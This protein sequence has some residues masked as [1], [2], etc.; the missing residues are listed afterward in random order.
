MGSIIRSRSRSNPYAKPKPPRMGRWDIQGLRAFAVLAVVFDH[1]FAQP[2]GGFVG[3]DIFFVISG[4]LITGLLVRE[5]ER[6]GHISFVGFYRRRIKR[7][8]PA[9][10]LVLIVTAVASHAIFNSVRSKSISTDAIWAFLFGANWHFRDI[11]TDYF[12]ASAAISPLQH[13]WSLSIEEQFYFVWPWVMLAVFALLLGR[14]VSFNRAR[15]VI[16]VVITAATVGSF[17]WALHETSTNATGAYFSTFS[18]AWELGLG[19]MCAVATPIFYRLSDALRPVLAWIGLTAITAS[20]FVVDASGGFP[21]PWAALPVAATALVIVA[22][23]HP[24]KGWQQ[25]FLVPLTNPVS[26]Y[27][28]DVSYSLYLWHFPV[29]IIGKDALGETTKDELILLVVMALLSVFSFHLVEDPIRHSTLWEMTRQKRRDRRAPY[30]PTTNAVTFRNTAIAFLSCVVLGANAVAFR[31]VEQP[32]VIELPQPPAFGTGNTPKAPL[33]PLQA[34][35]QTKI[36]AAISASDWPSLSPSFEQV[37]SGPSA[38]D[39]VHSCGR[40]AHVNVAACSWGANDARR[41]AVIAGDSISVLYAVT[42]RKMFEDLGGW[43]VY[44]YGGF[45]CPFTKA[46]VKADDPVLQQNCPGRNADAVKAIRDLRPDLLVI[47]NSVNPST[48]VGADV[49]MDEGSWAADLAAILRP[50]IKDA[51]HTV[52]ISPPPPDRTLSE[53]YAPHRSPTECVGRITDQWR[54]RARTDKNVAEQL[55]AI[56]LDSSLWFCFQSYCPSFIDG[57]V[58]KVDNTH[59]TPKYARRIAPLVEEAL[60]A[61]KVPVR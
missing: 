54:A 24:E 12:T 5:H 48:L 47:S 6:T 56:W 17:V 14:K 1:L 18:R 39:D 49:A 26:T 43:K 10:T 28:G 45:G 4:F 22:G 35:L 38:P 13:Y 50:L 44:L 52:I 30:F 41:T 37:L 34:A 3:V 46:V 16:F 59:M 23:T 55:G 8:L 19:A 15:S 57:V 36:A 33:L 20:L 27:I 11:G 2:K 29:I 9:A 31:P 25:P 60:V 7:I 32:K 61:A 40:S 53:C 51:R 42:L 58:V 21:A